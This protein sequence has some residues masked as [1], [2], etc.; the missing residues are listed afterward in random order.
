M[1]NQSGKTSGNQY[2][3]L[4][5]CTAHLLIYQVFHG[6][7]NSGN[8]NRWVSWR[9]ALKCEKCSYVS[10]DYNLVCPA[11]NKDLSSVRSK[12]GIHYAEPEYGLEEFLTGAPGGVATTAPG[13]TRTAQVPA[14]GSQEAELDLDSVGDD[15][16][17][18][19]DD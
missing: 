12:L 3:L 6:N 11:C 7:L 9:C 13:A 14:T 4:L 16:E 1:S 5:P 19:L 10:F 8:R 17:F 15:F 2:S 18:T